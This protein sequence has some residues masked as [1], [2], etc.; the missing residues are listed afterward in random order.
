MKLHIGDYVSFYI[1]KNGYSV[2]VD[3]ELY[4]IK[5]FL[6]P[7]TFKD[8]IIIVSLDGKNEL[9]TRK[10]KIFLRY[11]KE[12]VPPSQLSFLDELGG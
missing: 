4:R 10:N 12:D 2:A 6:N 7:Y 9:K 11:R 5:G 3:K 1:F 8:Y